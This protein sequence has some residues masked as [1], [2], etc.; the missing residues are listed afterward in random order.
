VS[1]STKHMCGYQKA[2]SNATG[3]S[4]TLMFGGLPHESLICIAFAKYKK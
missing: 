1:S 3:K 2:T 4:S